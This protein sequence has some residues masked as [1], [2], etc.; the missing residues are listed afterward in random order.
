MKTDR[1]DLTTS[2]ASNTAVSNEVSQ[3]N[4]SENQSSARQQLEMSYAY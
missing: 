1:L 3:M 4:F 2:I